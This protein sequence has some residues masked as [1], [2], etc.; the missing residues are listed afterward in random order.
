[1][2]SCVKLRFGV[3]K[4]HRRY[5]IVASNIGPGQTEHRM[6]VHGGHVAEVPQAEVRWGQALTF[7]NLQVGSCRISDSDC[8]YRPSDSVFVIKNGIGFALKPV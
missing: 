1:V 7:S 3:P 5:E 8:F 6:Q 4:R 2:L